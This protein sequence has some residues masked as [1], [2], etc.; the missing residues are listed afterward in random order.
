MKP[1]GKST[2]SLQISVSEEKGVRYLHFGT[3]WVQGAMRIR[4]PYLLELDYARHMMAWLLFAPAP[5]QLLQIGLGAGSLAKFIHRHLPGISQ[6]IV[7][8][9]VDVMH[10]ARSQFSCPPDDDRLE[11][12]ID[13]G[14]RFVA[15]PR[16]KKTFDVMQVDVFDASARGPVLDST[17]FYRAC[18]NVL[19]PGGVMA[20]NLFG[21]VPSYSRNFK[22]ICDAFGSRVLVLPPIEAGNVIVLAFREHADER[23]DGPRW[24]WPELRLRA[25]EIEQQYGLNAHG[26]VNGLK[27]TTEKNISE[28]L[29]GP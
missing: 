11:T 25:D 9:S 24:R 6:T 19:V 22:N 12:I 21:D 8:N 2:D 16:L 1:G 29:I 5:Q 3:E 7:E 13:D 15:Q 17:E 27:T 10:V 20:V 23:D 26:W 18:R 28:A 4:K 14:E